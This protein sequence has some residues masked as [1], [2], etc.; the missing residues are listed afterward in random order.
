MRACA[1]AQT[2]GHSIRWIGEGQVQVVA[3][4]LLIVVGAFLSRRRSATP[5]DQRVRDLVLAAA[6]LKVLPPPP[7]GPAPSRIHS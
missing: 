6:T 3:L 5:G 4:L 1:L 7:L 2:I